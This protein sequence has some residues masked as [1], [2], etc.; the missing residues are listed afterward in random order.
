[1]NVRDEV[2][3]YLEY[4]EFRKEL[5][6][7]SLK[8]YRIDLSIRAFYNYLEGEELV[9]EAAFRRIKVSLKKI[10]FYQGLYRGRK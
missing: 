9:S 1:M 2:N 6:Q 5:D 7:K 4:C 10:S 8:A 3:R